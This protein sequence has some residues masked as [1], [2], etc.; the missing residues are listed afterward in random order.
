MRQQVHSHCNPTHSCRTSGFQHLNGMQLQ[1]EI[2]AAWQGITQMLIPLS[3]SWTTPP[4][5]VRFDCLLQ[6]CNALMAAPTASNITDSLARH[7]NDAHSMPPAQHLHESPAAPTAIVLPATQPRTAPNIN[8]TG[9]SARPSTLSL[10]NLTESERLPGNFNCKAD[11]VVGSADAAT[12]TASAGASGGSANVDAAHIANAAPAASKH[13]A[14]RP[15]S[16]SQ[17]AS[18]AAQEMHNVSSK[19]PAAIFWL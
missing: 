17:Q 2:P 3:C 10:A 6:D 8:L 19:Q 16:N 11:L 1:S 5:T 7:D 18:D 4:F 15:I 14:Q 12:A 13:E 9:S